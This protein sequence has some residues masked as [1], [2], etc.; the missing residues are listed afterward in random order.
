MSAI[1]Q[2]VL[3]FFGL[4]AT[5]RVPGIQVIDP[6]SGKLTSRSVTP[7]TAMQLSAV[8]SC[9]RLL[10]ET[11]ASLPLNFYETQAGGKRVRIFQHD[12]HNL[13]STKPNRYQTKVEFFET[14]IYQLAL[15]GNAYH[16]ID[17]TINNQVISLLPLMSPQVQPIL[18]NDGRVV[19][20]YN[21]GRTQMNYA[22]ENVWHNKLFGNGIVG[23]SPL[24]YARNVLGIA[25]SAEDRVNKMANTGFKQAG[26]LSIDK[27][28]TKDQ[29]ADIR[30]NYS[31]L[32]DGG[33]DALTVLGHGM[34][35][36]PTVMNPKDV[37]LL[38][39]R[40]FEIEDIARF[41]GVPSVLINDT[42]ASTVWGSGIQQIIQ[43]FYK[44]GLRPYIERIEAS[45]IIWLLDLK[46]RFRIDPEFDL[47][48]LLRGDEKSRYESYQIA[49]RNGVKTVN[50]CRQ[51]EGDSPITGG[52][53]PLIQQQLVKL[54]DIKKG[55]KQ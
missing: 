15:H 47:D 26:T 4:G 28:L 42:S 53:E 24:G 49:I 37:Q 48:E 45:I 9:V 52:D 22:L 19:Y 40:R 23:L 17:R 41:F 13:L 3:S 12:L 7:E 2:N 21:N 16:K 50:E 10:A 6:V 27:V 32:V 11:I 5:G 20:Q 35:Y 38:E 31:D 8:F 34:V 14:L 44:L 55:G 18:E 1:W 30:T 51:R 43:G 33:D 36:Q 29:R 54:G 39:T 25:I 46:E